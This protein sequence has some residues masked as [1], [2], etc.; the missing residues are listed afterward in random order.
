MTSLPP[1]LHVGSDL[2]HSLSVGR[3]LRPVRKAELPR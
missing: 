3:D 2:G 1:K